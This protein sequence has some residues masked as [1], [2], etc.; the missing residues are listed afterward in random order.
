M[1]I[2]FVPSWY[3]PDGGSFFRDQAM[4]L[5]R[6]GHEVSVLYAKR[7]ATRDVVKTPR[8]AFAS[9]LAISMENGLTVYRSRFATIPRVRLAYPLFY[10]MGCARV[11]A[12]YV[13]AQGAPDIIHAH[14]SVWAGYAAYWIGR[15]YGIPYVITEH[16]GR[17]TLRTRE[18]QKQVKPWFPVYLKGAFRN[19]SGVILVGSHLE[20]GL[21]RYRVS[22]VPWA[23][24]PNAVDTDVFR[25]SLRSPGN[26]LTFVFVGAL[27]HLKGVDL[28]F[29][30]FLRVNREH[31]DT[32]LL[33]I[34]DGPERANLDAFAD[35]NRIA[36]SVTFTGQLSREGVRDALQIGDV[37][38]LPTRYDA[39]GVAYLE[40]MSCGLPIIT[41]DG[42]PPE[43]CP[44][45]AG[46]C[47]PIDD[48][49]ALESAMLQMQRDYSRFD[50][51]RIREFAVAHYDFAVVASQIQDFYDL[52]L[53]SSKASG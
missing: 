7:Y 47:V 10:G 15:R 6:R 25:P 1:K 40:A 42:A 39:Q 18:A 50:R 5:L 11:F 33:V 36:D 16:R 35:N 27:A 21:G 26:T 2:L 24:I 4:A 38:V 46:L 17:F 3:P 49:L 19:A 52:V 29:S 8:L 12:A 43:I 31:P 23:V 22:G 32:R 45:F 48:A 44:D 34:G 41:T 28:L 30:A 14:S 13:D 20:R 53:S 51:A 9:G 37:F